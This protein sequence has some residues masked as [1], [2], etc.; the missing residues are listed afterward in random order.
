MFDAILWDY[1]GTIENIAVTM[2]VF[3]RLA[4]ALLVCCR[5]AWLGPQRT[6]SSCCSHKSQSN[7]EDIQK[8]NDYLTRF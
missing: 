1:D 4:P 7:C 3:Q 6:C 8:V 5:T 2:A